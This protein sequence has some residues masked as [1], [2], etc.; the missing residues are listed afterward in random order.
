MNKYM[1]RFIGGAASVLAL[2]PVTQPVLV[3]AAV[4]NRSDAEALRGDV[5]RIGGDFKRATDRVM[6]D[7]KA[8]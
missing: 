3:G 8:V 2:F 1:K 5:E 4:H 7:E 6:H